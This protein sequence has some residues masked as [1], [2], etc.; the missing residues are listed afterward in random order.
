[1]ATSLLKQAKGAK[2]RSTAKKN[3]VNSTSDILK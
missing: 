1:M 2:N 3:Q